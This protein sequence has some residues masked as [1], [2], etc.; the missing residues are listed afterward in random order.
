MTTWR[1]ALERCM[2]RHGEQL[3]DIVS[4][5]MTAAEMDTEFN[6]DYGGSEGCPFTVWTQ[7]RVYFPAVYDGAEWVTSV[8]RSPNGERTEHVGGE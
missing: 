7:Y 8:P 5:T 2:H 6:D 4:N 3:S 1:R